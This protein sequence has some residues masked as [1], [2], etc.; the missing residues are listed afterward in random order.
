M[1]ETTGTKAETILRSAC[2]TLLHTSPNVVSALSVSIAPNEAPGTVEEW[3]AIANELAQQ[4]ELQVE[5][6]IPRRYLHVRFS[7]Y[8]DGLGK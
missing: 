6:T 4:Y 8:T 5:V 2:E 1:I 3:Q 7:R